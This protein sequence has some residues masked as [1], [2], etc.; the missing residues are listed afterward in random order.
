MIENVPK[1]LTDYLRGTASDF[2][3]KSFYYFA[4]AYLGLFYLGK[5]FAEP[6]T[7]DFLD[8][9]RTSRGG[10]WY[11]HVGRVLLIGSVAVFTN[12]AWKPTNV[13]PLGSSTMRRE[14]EF[15]R[16]VDSVFR[17]NDRTDGEHKLR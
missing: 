6:E 2:D 15:F 13:T 8:I 10:I 11:G 9:Q 1:R 12:D 14:S 3:R 5:N 17:T 16:W 4:A 7:S